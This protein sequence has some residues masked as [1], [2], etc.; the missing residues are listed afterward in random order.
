MER[1]NGGDKMTQT[2]VLIG[3]ILYLGVTNYIERQKATAREEDLLNRLM[4]KRFSEYVHGK[5][6]LKTKEKLLK[7]AN[8]QEIME[9]ANRLEAMNT[10]V[11]P[12]S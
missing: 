11:L 4:S 1:D 3:I 7:D 5:K 2:I 8:A 6:V 12:V 10:D 9:Q